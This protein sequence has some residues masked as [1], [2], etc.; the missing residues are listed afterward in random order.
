MRFKLGTKVNPADLVGVDFN[1]CAE[2]FEKIAVAG[3]KVVV[4]IIFKD[5]EPAL[6]QFFTKDWYT[7]DTME[8]IIATLKDYYE[9]EEVKT[10]ILEAS[11]RKLVCVDS[12]FAISYL[13]C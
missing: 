3:I 7:Q 8:T 9:N 11:F 1:G 10:R 2:V 12:Y 6:A 4:S 13:I 5:L